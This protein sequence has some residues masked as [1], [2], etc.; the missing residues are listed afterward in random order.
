MCWWEC[1][2]EHYESSSSVTTTP[3]V[4][5]KEAIMPTNCY[6]HTH[7]ITHM[8]SHL[9]HCS[10]RNGDHSAVQTN[11]HPAVDFENDSYNHEEVDVHQQNNGNATAAA[12][13]VPMVTGFGNAVPT[14]LSDLPPPYKRDEVTHA[15]YHADNNM[16]TRN[17]DHYDKLM[18][19]EN[20]YDVPPT[21][22]PV[23][24]NDEKMAPPLPTK[25]QDLDN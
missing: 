10:R 22:V 11:S 23:A 19:T 5:H 16:A 17:V 20:S 8:S 9:N 21:A 6:N 15:Y 24:D 3:I 4:N 7:N 13:H 18:V 2:T 12:I 25:E 14:T 1:R